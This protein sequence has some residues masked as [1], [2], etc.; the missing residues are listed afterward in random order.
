MTD[1]TLGV[2]IS[3]DHLDVFDLEA[4]RSE[5]FENTKAGLGRFRRWL[6]SRLLAR[7]VYEPTGPYHRLFESSFSGRLPLVKV[8]P[9]QAR[10]FAEACGRRAK[11]DALDA[12]MLARMGA[13]LGLVPD[14][15]IPEEAVLLKDLARARSALIEDRTRTAHRRQGPTSALL[16]RQ[17]KARLDL[18]LRQIAELDDEIAARIAASPERARKGCI[19]QSIPGLGRVTTAMLLIFLPE[20]GLLDRR[21]LGSLAG[22]V[23]HNRDSGRTRGKARITGGRKPLRDALY[24]PAL[25]ATR[26]NPDFKAKFHALCTAGKPKKLALVAIMRK[27]LELANALVRDDRNWSPKNP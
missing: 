26:H 13:T 24:M 18:T 15:P 8:N 21:Q 6:G 11:T 14:T 17:A 12:R 25:V 9:L 20:I 16:R 23:P 4:E 27:L 7:V 2:D 19:L 3:K 10:R 5:R 1:H 22:L